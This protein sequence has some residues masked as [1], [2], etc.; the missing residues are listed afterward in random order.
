MRGRPPKAKKAQIEAEIE[1][2]EEIPEVEVPMDPIEKIVADLKAAPRQIRFFSTFAAGYAIIAGHDYIRFQD[3]KLTTDDPEIVRKLLKFERYGFHIDCLDTEIRKAL[4]QGQL[5]VPGVGSLRAQLEASKPSNAI[6][7]WLENRYQTL[8]AQPSDI[9][10]HLPMLREYASQSPRIVEFGFR[11]GVSTV[12]LLCG[13]PKQMATVDINPACKPIYD[14]IR[15]QVPREIIFNFF[16][17]DSLKF[18]FEE[19]DLLFIDSEHSYE[20]LKA[21]LATHA[22]KVKKW[23]ILHDTADYAW[24]K[25]D[26]FSSGPGLNLAIAELLARGGWVVEKNVTYNNGLT[27]LGRVS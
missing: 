22:E 4:G 16:C 13:G 23:I 7:T 17:M 11:A 21:E 3:S 18:P 9:N 14:E 24:G 5:S 2:E 8:C 1:T 10:E 12:A 19:T 20:H 6:G 25:K 26:E 27:V 15:A